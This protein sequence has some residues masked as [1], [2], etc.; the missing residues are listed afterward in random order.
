MKR[1]KEYLIPVLIIGVLFLILFLYYGITPFGSNTILVYDMALQTYPNS[2][3]F[4]DVFHGLK[5]LI[6]N[7][8]YGAGL[9]MIPSAIMNG[10]FS[11][12]NWIFF[13]CNR[14][15]VAMMLGIMVVVKFWFISIATQFSLKRIF[16]EAKKEDIIIATLCYTLSSY[17][18]LYFENFQWI[19]CW[20]LFPLVMLGIKRIGEGKSSL[21]YVV[22]YS[23][24]LF[25]SYYMAW[26]TILISLFGGFLYFWFFVS[27][28]NRMKYGARMFV[29]TLIS[30]MIP[31]VSFWP[32][33]KV[34]LD[35]YRVVGGEVKNIGNPI[36]Y[37]LLHIIGSP[38]LL[39]YLGEY[40]IN[41]KKD[42]KR[43]VFYL[44][45]VLLV[46]V[47]PMLLEPINKMWHTGS[48]SGLPYRYGFIAIFL[49]CLIMIRSRINNN[50][51][52]EK[53][54][55]TLGRLISK[56]VVI[57]LLICTLGFQVYNLSIIGDFTYIEGKG[58]NSYNADKASMV[59]IPCY[60][61]VLIIVLATIL[62]DKKFFNKV[63][64]ALFFIS[65]FYMMLLYIK[66]NDMY[67]Y[68]YENNETVMFAEEINR[69]IIKANPKD[70]Y[71]VKTINGESFS[72][73]GLIIE[74]PTIANWYH[75]IPKLQVEAFDF[76]GYS[77][78]SSVQ[79]SNGGTILSDYLVG[80]K[81][82]LG[83][84]T[85]TFN[86]EQ[87]NKISDYLY[88]NYYEYAIPFPSF[89]KIIKDGEGIKDW[90]NQ[91]VK[92]IFTGT[93]FVYRKWLEEDNDIIKVIDYTK[94][95]HLDPEDKDLDVIE[96]NFTLDNSSILYSYIRQEMGDIRAHYDLYKDNK[97]INVFIDDN[98]YPRTDFNGIF[99]IGFFEKGNYKLV[100]TIADNT[101]IEEKKQIENYKKPEMKEITLGALDYEKFKASIEKYNEKAHTEIKYGKNSMRVDAIGKE[102]EYLLVPIN[103]SNG[104]KAKINGEPVEVEEGLGFLMVKLHEG[105][106]AVDF[107][108]TP[109]Y[110]DLGIKVTIISTIIY[111]LLLIVFNKGAFKDTKAAKAI[112][113]L[114]TGLYFVLSIALYFVVYVY[115]FFR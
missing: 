39:Y 7:F 81:Y 64:V 59:F 93:N 47:L 2:V 101:P 69:H 22:S 103:Y 113:V 76:L 78:A 24:L 61:E 15:K 55:F 14:N 79:Y 111:I 30:L 50:I 4:N 48:Y 36:I 75:F 112:Y 56:I 87:Y 83:N 65:T 105:K 92:N 70:D 1:I 51:E 29:A 73:S 3:F 6:F 86:D 19:E 110:I 106:N 8:D 16:P 82:I 63:V 20:G 18:L 68:N 89:A 44:L 104:W 17:S 72:T 100:V 99:E 94:A 96:Y 35:S 28:E 88:E 31:F 58:I 13:I 66:P 109:R 21:L 49:M 80:N 107:K 71:R 52:Y 26:L 11:P 57:I 102:G 40:F 32:A 10:M 9:E 43:S 84:N 90:N 98:T 37:K 114:G 38:I 27:K 5:S 53:R 108:Y 46:I 25:I 67:S 23:I 54:D 85:Y 41:F 77:R 12:L 91:E 97:K 60:I 115:S 34:S 95:E 42:K 62:K 33:L 45:L 74:K